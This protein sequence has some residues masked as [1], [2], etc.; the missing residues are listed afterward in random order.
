MSVV[1][2]PRGLVWNCAKLR[3]SLPGDGVDCQ[4]QAVLAARVAHPKVAG[5]SHIEVVPVRY[6]APEASGASSVVKP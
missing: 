2:P 4:E 6:H 1:A 3:R 5:T